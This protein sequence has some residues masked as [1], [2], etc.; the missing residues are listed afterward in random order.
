M[1]TLLIV[2]A[3][4]KLWWRAS[5]RDDG[6]MLN[7]AAILL[8]IAAVV[9]VMAIPSIISQRQNANIVRAKTMMNELAQEPMLSMVAAENGPAIQADVSA[10]ARE[11]VTVRYD[12]TAASTGQDDVVAALY[13]AAAPTSMT[14]VVLVRG[15]VCIIVT[16]DVAKGFTAAQVVNPAVPDHQCTPSGATQPAATITVTQA[17]PVASHLVLSEA[18][19]NQGGQLARDSVTITSG[20]G[21]VVGSTFTGYIRFERP[22]GAGTT[23]IAFDYTVAGTVFQGTLTVNYG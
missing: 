20:G 4:V 22:E 13:P 21:E 15:G 10:R 5:N 6:F 18:I 17:E 9:V 12:A 16:A 23:V 8:I 3:H 19:T 14:G 7:K 2:A 1:L 11:G